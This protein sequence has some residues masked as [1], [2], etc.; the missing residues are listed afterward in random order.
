MG[1][2]ATC[3]NR[4]Q[5]HCNTLH[6]SASLTSKRRRREVEVHP[7]LA[8]T[9]QSGLRDYRRRSVNSTSDSSCTPKP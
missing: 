1:H 8:P 6:V 2:T 4:M 3:T 7:L 9:H 5:F